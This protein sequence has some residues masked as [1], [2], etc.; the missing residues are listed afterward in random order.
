MAISP[1]FF[2]AYLG[3]SARLGAGE[4]FIEGDPEGYADRL[5][6]YLPFIR[7]ASVLAEN[8]AA[9]PEEADA[10]LEL[11]LAEANSGLP[12][13]ESTKFGMTADT[14]VRQP[15]VTA[16]ARA[17]EALVRR[18]NTLAKSG[19]SWGAIELAVR[20]FAIA[21]LTRHF[22]SRSLNLST[23][24]QVVLAN[25][26]RKHLSDLSADQLERLSHRLVAY[27]AKRKGISGILRNEM[28]LLTMESRCWI[29]DFDRIATLSVALD[30]LR[31][32]RRGESIER[33]IHRTARWEAS[34]AKSDVWSTLVSWELA[35]R[36]EDHSQRVIRSL[37]VEV[38]SRQLAL[39]G[40]KFDTIAALRLP[41][42]FF[43]E[44][45]KRHEPILVLE[46][47]WACLH[48]DVDPLSE[49][50]AVR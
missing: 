4:A 24:H 38:R 35:S 25:F 29:G 26:L 19:N 2:I 31:T 23:S 22:D 43:A 13:L 27:E 8:K 46:R 14:D 42:T 12:L 37:I 49:V 48:Y 17:F 33:F 39:R 11:A 32:F 9:S 21:D 36:S 44:T 40:E 18:A 6:A 28:H 47:N 7:A 5:E 34:P 3:L 45:I 30:A 15:I 41:A 20:G 16:Q 10:A 50:V 1:L